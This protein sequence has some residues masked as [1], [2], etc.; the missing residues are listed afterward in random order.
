MLIRG[1]MWQEIAAL[2]QVELLYRARKGK[3]YDSLVFVSFIE[4]PIR[5]V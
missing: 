2:I 3:V 4:A 5:S 1:E